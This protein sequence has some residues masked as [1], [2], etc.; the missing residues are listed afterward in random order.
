MSAVTVQV[1]GGPTVSVNWTQGITVQQAL[2][3][4]FNQQTSLG[5]FTYALSYAGIL[6]GGGYVVIMINATFDTSVTPVGPYFYWV[7][8]VNG[9]LS[10]T[11][12][13]TNTTLN[14]GDAVSFVFQQFKPSTRNEMSALSAKH[15]FHTE[16]AKKSKGAAKATKA[17][18]KSKR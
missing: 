4:V 13:V 10:S 3:G 6:L 17:A 15:D 7:F 1:Q 18:K 12:N 2:E 14:S 11:G 5:Q 8:S 9:T 16:A